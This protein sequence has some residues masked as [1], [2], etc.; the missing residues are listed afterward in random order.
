MPTYG[1][2]SGDACLRCRGYW[3]RIKGRYFF[4]ATPIMWALIPIVDEFSSIV[5]MDCKSSSR[6]EHLSNFLPNSGISQPKLSIDST[7]SNFK[8]DLVISVFNSSTSVVQ[9]ICVSLC[10][11]RNAENPITYLW[12]CRDYQKGLQRPIAHFL[13]NN[14]LFRRQRTICI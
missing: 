13:W 7:V 6:Y 1:P 8:P 10:C 4:I 5:R 12:F 11:N 14:E 9:N 3:L 2:E